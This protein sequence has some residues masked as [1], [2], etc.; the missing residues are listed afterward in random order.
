MSFLKSVIFGAEGSYNILG[1]DVT[2]EKSNSPSYSFA[3]STGGSGVLSIFTK[4]LGYLADNCLNSNVFRVVTQG[5]AHT[6][7]HEM[8]HALA[9]RVL[10]DVKPKVRV[11]TDLCTGRTYVGDPGSLIDSIIC[12]SGP[13][14]NMAFSGCKLVGATALRG[15]LSMPVAITIG[16]GAIVWMTG[17]LFLAS[18]SASDK[19][20]G[21]FGR[22]A[23]YGSTNLTLA[24]T[25]LIGQC[26]LGV[27][28]ACKF[29]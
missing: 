19:D 27:L 7:V 11:F 15:Y 4:S 23:R 28:A 29:M 12:A 8:G 16:A 24:S 1:V 13:L 25:A 22:I 17:E 20:L 9:C 5:Y 10:T 2:F 14:A 26:A 6:F 18:I 3:S 21:D